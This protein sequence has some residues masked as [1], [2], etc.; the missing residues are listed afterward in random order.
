MIRVGS[1]GEIEGSEEE[2]VWR[3]RVEKGG[4]SRMMKIGSVKEVWRE[5]EKRRWVKRV[6]ERIWI[7]VNELWEKNGR[8]WWS[9]VVEGRIG[10]FGRGVKMWGR[11][12][13]GFLDGRRRMVFRG[14][15]DMWSR[16]RIVEDIRGVIV[17]WVDEV[18]CW[19]VRSKVKVGR[20]G[21]VEEGGRRMIMGWRRKV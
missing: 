7:I 4:W 20:R 15:E 8:N 14:G 13:F 17:L 1:I 19:N 21:K 18:D 2:G 16:R 5:E 6:R 3:V 11:M 9:E 10:V 12:V